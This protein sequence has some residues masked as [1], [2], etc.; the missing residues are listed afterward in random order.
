[1]SFHN[2]LTCLPLAGLSTLRFEN[3]AGARPSEALFKYSILRQ[4]PG[5]ILK[6]WTRLERSAMDKHSSLLRAFI[7]YGHKKF[8]I[9]GLRS[10][11]FKMY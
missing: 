9:F 2:K 8:S 3:N 5:L 11:Y 7:N 4:A 10:F 1:M 6:R